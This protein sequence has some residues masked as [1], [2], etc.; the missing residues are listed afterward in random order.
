MLTSPEGVKE[1]VFKPL[2]HAFLDMFFPPLCHVCHSFIPDADELHICPA[3]RAQMM[4]LGRPF[5][6]VCGIPFLGAGDDHLCGDCIRHPPAYDA[7]R[8][9]I[10]YAGPVCKLIHDFKYTHK[11]HLRRPLAL[12]IIQHL[13]DVVAGHDWDLIIPVPLHVRRLRSRGFNQAVLLGELLARK[14]RLPMERRTLRRVR[15]TEPQI[16]LPAVDRRDNVKGAFAVHDVARVAGK[17]VILLDDVMTTGSTVNEC[18]AV[19]KKA[20]AEE[21][22]VVTVSRALPDSI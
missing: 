14:W 19:L 12:L 13:N 22:L 8:A 5:C 1:K 16:N 10:A 17:R 11:V 7:A 15:W 18:A 6:S 9:A 20:G 21:I 3:C 4:P 2:L